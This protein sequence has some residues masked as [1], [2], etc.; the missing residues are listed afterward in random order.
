M[1]NIEGVGS[2]RAADI[3]LFISL[4]LVRIFFDVVGDAIYFS[5]GK[6]FP[7]ICLMDLVL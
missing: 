6:F 1:T 2:H 5:E 4:F 7:F 3:S